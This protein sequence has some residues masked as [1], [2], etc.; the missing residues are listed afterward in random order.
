MLPPAASTR[1]LGNKHEK[2][3]E[4]TQVNMQTPVPW[5]FPSSFF[6]VKT[7]VKPIKVMTEPL[8]EIQALLKRY[9]RKRN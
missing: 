6:N 2:E 5:V 7:S 8:F 9:Q 1:Y 4:K 3:E